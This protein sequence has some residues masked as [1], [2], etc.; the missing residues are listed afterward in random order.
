MHNSVTSL[1]YSCSLKYV[2][3]YWDILYI[4]KT[5][6]LIKNGLFYSHK[7][8]MMLITSTVYYSVVPGHI[9]YAGNILVHSRLKIKTKEH[10]LMTNIFPIKKQD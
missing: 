2:C 4:Q 7:T 6:P 3:F 9:P 10:E 1:S 8:T 5:E